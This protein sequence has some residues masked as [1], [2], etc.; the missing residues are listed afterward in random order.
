MAIG[1]AVCIHECRRRQ[2]RNSAGSKIW[3]RH[4]NPLRKHAASRKLHPRCDAECPGYVALGIKS[5]IYTYQVTLTVE[6]LEAM[7]DDTEDD[8]EMSVDGSDDDDDNGDDSDDNGD[9]SDD[10][11]DDVD[12]MNVDDGDISTPFFADPVARLSSASVPVS[13]EPSQ[14]SDNHTAIDL[15]T[16]I[17]QFEARAAQLALDDP[18]K[19]YR[20]IYVP[21]PTRYGTRES[22]P[23]DLAF[24]KT[25][26]SEIEWKNIKHLDRSVFLLRHKKSNGEVTVYMQEWVHDHYSN[27]FAQINMFMIVVSCDSPLADC[28]QKN[29][30]ETVLCGICQLGRFPRCSG[31]QK[32]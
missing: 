19:P 5:G 4:G 17:S 11:G 7:V 23:S 2:C 30:H 1:Y 15:N 28:L 26:I 21:D 16:E 24:M 8:A 10:N 14:G 27:V 20:L 12:G 29:A 22:A 32:L 6:Q 31:R 13:R 3:T 18:I 25:T 9:D